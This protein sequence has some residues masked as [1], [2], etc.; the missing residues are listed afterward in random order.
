MAFS[1]ALTLTDLNDY[2]GPS[3]AC[4]KPV[5]G[6]DAPDASFIPEED[7]HAASTQIAVESSGVYE[8]NGDS[9]PGGAAPSSSQSK[10]RARTKLEAAEISLNDCLA[11]SGC[12]TS[13]ESV[14]IG[15]Q[16]L[17][18]IRRVVEENMSA[19]PEERKLLVASISPQS[20]ASLSARYSLQDSSLPSSSTASQAYVP[21]PVIISRITHF[22]RSHFAF[23]VVLDT[24]FPR[25]LALQEHAQEF[26]QRREHTKSHP[27]ELAQLPMLASAC[28]GWVCYAEK[29]HG[30]LLPLVGRTKSPQQVAGSLVKKWLSTQLP[31]P[32]QRGEGGGSGQRGIY[33]VTIM[34]CY[35]KKLE[36]SRPDFYDEL[37]GTRDVDCVITTGEL[38]RLMLEEG[39]DITQQVEVEDFASQ[40]LPSLL[41]E[42]SPGSSSGGYLFSLMQEVWREYLSTHPDLTIASPS[43]PHVDF[44]IIRT[45]D[46]TEYTLRAPSSGSNRGGILFRG[47][48]C[49]GFRN[50]QN[51]VRK[52]QRQVG[53][54]SRKSGAAG[55]LTGA[56]T[57]EGA[58]RAGRGRAGRGRVMRGGGLRGRGVARGGIVRKARDGDVSNGSASSALVNGDDSDMAAVPVASTPEEEE[59]AHGYDYIEV[60]ACPSGCVNGG[61]QIRPP[62]TG[63]AGKASGVSM[64]TSSGIVEST[65]AQVDTPGTGNGSKSD[66]V[67]IGDVLRPKLDSLA[68][69]LDPEGYPRAQEHP[70]PPSSSAFSDIRSASGFSTPVDTATGTGATTPLS[71]GDGEPPM[72]SG[73]QGTSKE[74]VKRVEEAYWSTAG[75]TST[76]HSSAPAKKLAGAANSRSRTQALLASTTATPSAVGM[77]TDIDD[78]QRKRKEELDGLTR[79]VLSFLRSQGKGE[80]GLMRTDYRAVEEEGAVNGLA[81]QW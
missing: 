64:L 11:C 22:L 48:H 46:Y 81:V 7:P 69:D 15:M 42:N 55:T 54:K 19:T 77:E 20:L 47:A 66:S 78:E 27:D 21:L 24:T 75:S 26:F 18:E 45:S 49:Y 1:G 57:S 14:L 43:P 2:L 32:A 10:P 60:M 38:D 52:V 13:A 40:L 4:I 59:Q 58:G 36:A 37:L 8:T 6:K 74:W 16:S 56:D 35:D 23:D 25:H 53:V 9:A 67:T 73:W 62:T 31:A 68:M 63:E 17:E 3:Q 5:E 28:P 50:L 72:T 44:K 33:H 79:E 30:E 12:V 29:T 41:H 65:E 61:G 34:P 76:L 70:A 80:G 39:F 51:L 71:T